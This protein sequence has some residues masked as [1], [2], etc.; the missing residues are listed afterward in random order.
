MV[1]NLTRN[2]MLLLGDATGYEIATTV[3][4]KIVKP[5]LDRDQQKLCTF[6][7]TMNYFQQPCFS[8]IWKTVIQLK[9][10]IKPLTQKRPNL[11]LKQCSLTLI[12][13]ISHSI[14]LKWQLLY[15]QLLMKMKKT[16]W[17]FDICNTKCNRASID[18]K[19][20]CCC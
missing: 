7:K 15:Q 19:E 9:K 8:Q 20:H 10:M 1:S 3:H 14:L 17:S 2:G 11:T 12:E 4:T 16:T 13:T 18:D 6:C 5:T